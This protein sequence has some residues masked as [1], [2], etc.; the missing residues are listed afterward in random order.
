ME[1]EEKSIEAF[2]SIPGSPVIGYQ[3]HP[4]AFN[5]NDPLKISEAHTNLLGFM[6]KAGIA[7]NRK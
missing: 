3:S 2:E 7:F 1:P 5:R 6:T 4:E